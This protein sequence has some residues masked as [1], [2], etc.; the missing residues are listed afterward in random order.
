M[1]SVKNSLKVCLL[2]IQHSIHALNFQQPYFS[3]Q[4][5]IF[6]CID[7][8]ESFVNYIHMSFERGESHHHHH[9]H[10]ENTKTSPPFLMATTNKGYPNT[11]SNTF[12]DSQEQHHH[13]LQFVQHQE[14]HHHDNNQIS[15]AMINHSMPS[16]SSIR[17]TTNTNNNIM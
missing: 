1:G 16:S 7:V 3:L 10:Q 12:L 5:L 13:Q 14:H 15:F 4:I 17:P 6:T 11:S 8:R 2:H 9:H